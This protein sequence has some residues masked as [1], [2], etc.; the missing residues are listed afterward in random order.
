[1]SEPSELPLRR[2]LLATDGSEDA[3]LAARAAVDLC[4]RTGAELHVAH[5]WHDIPS[6]RAHGFIRREL[7]RQ[8]REILDAQVEYVE[9]LGGEVREAH[10]QEGRSVDVI[11]RLSEET[12]ADLIVVG[13]RGLGTIK[14]LAL[15]SI[16][17]GI[18][19]RTTVPVLVMRGG[20]DAWPPERV[21]IGDDSSEESRAAGD[22]AAVICRLFEAQ[23]LLVRVQPQDSIPERTGRDLSEAELEEYLG[24]AREDLE[25]R[26]AELAALLGSPPQV[27][28]AAGDAA[29][30]ILGISEE[31]GPALLA[32]GSRG[33]GAMNRLRLGS[34]STKL[35]R[36]ARTPVL[37]AP[38]RRAA[39][40]IPGYSR[41]LAAG[42]GPAGE[43]HAVYLAGA[44][45]AKLYVLRAAGE[46]AG[47]L[48]R[49]AVER[50]L[51]YEVVTAGDEIER[52]AREV[53]ADC[54]VL[55]SGSGPDAEEL[56]RKLGKPVLLV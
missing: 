43:E 15:G 44:L 37:V 17:E 56:R 4:R 6:P 10:L 48:E 9:S 53:G 40:T 20:E 35:L 2:V 55:G 31:G 24:D 8:G 41:I 36:A 33:L 32:V 38:R 51:E 18:A 19:H 23:A 45:G 16:S 12:S 47:R 22:L 28:P 49:M 46:P 27:K 5:A 7:E 1:M 21:V 54:V 30:A 50:G 26:A 11:L 52:A 42:A 34:V 39:G 25:R 13:S 14:R 3:A 29:S